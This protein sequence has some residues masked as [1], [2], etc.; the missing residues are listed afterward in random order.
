MQMEEKNEPSFSRHFGDKGFSWLQISRN[1]SDFFRGFSLLSFLLFSRKSCGQHSSLEAAADRRTS[2]SA[3]KCDFLHHF[4]FNRKS[5]LP[6]AAAFTF[7]FLE[8]PVLVQSPGVLEKDSFSGSFSVF[9]QREAAY[10][11]S[12]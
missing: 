6:M 12:T 9:L 7:I 1:P 2:D 10:S 5:K 4:T 11:A 8:G 3:E